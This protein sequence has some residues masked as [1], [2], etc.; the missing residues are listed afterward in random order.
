M[1]AELGEYSGE[2]GEQH[3]NLSL[4]VTI[5]D[6]KAVHDEL[7]EKLKMKQRRF[8]PFKRINKSSGC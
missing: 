1:E 4:R 5:N 2:R 8:F 7:A 6:A 3:D